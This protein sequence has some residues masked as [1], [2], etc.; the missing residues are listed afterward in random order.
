VTASSP[1][2]A[3]FDCCVA[4]VTAAE[5]APP[6]ANRPLATRRGRV[7]LTATT[8]EDPMPATTT[9]R[10][11]ATRAAKPAD[12][13]GLRYLA[14]VHSALLE[15]G[16]APAAGRPISGDY[17]NDWVGIEYSVGRATVRVVTRDLECRDLLVVVADRRGVEAARATFANLPASSVA[18]VIAAE[19]RS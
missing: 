13:D 18:A 7:I 16:F 3:D 6:I 11:A 12:P 1:F 17:P 5:T 14:D 19:V 15:A 10:A 4:A 2:G 9:R 8:L